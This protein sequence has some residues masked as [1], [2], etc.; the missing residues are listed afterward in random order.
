MLEIGLKPVNAE[1]GKA[2]RETGRKMDHVILQG[3]PFEQAL[4]ALL[5]RDYVVTYIHEPHPPRRHSESDEDEQKEREKEEER[6]RR[7]RESKTRFMCPRCGQ[8]AW[9]RLACGD[10]KATMLIPGDPP[11]DQVEHP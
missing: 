2:H 10:C 9:A 4:F 6:K 1:K 3:G 8:N 5:R 7:K 11:A